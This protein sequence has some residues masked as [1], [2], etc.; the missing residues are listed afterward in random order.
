[1]TYAIAVQGNRIPQIEPTDPLYIRPLDNPGIS[2]VSNAF[3]G[4]NFDNW[5]RSVIIALSA[6]HKLALIDGHCTNLGSTSPLFTFWQRHNA[7]VLS[8]LLNSLTENIRNNVLY[9]ETAR[10]LWQD[11]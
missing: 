4:E 7:M 10:E 5:K 6:K 3:N 8:W 11:L 2:L 1:M 9:F